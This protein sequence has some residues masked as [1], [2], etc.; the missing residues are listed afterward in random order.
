[1][2]AQPQ[3]SI[4]VGGFQHET[5]T[6]APSK[7]EYA[8]FVSGGGFPG[9][10]FGDDVPAAVAGA[11]LPAAGACEVFRAA[12]HRTIGLVWAAA[13]PSAH[14]RREAYEQIAGEM[15]TRLK[16]PSAA[17]TASAAATFSGESTR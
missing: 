9:I 3:W 7:A 11:N 6:F 14:V 1:M 2:A 13:S 16:R 8:A 17:R 5:N 12:G 15:V 10:C 4:A